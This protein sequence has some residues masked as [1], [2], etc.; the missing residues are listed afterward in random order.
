MSSA[1]PIEVVDTDE[2]LAGPREKHDIQRVL[3][4]ERREQIDL[5]APPEPQA[6]R[7]GQHDQGQRQCGVDADAGDEASLPHCSSLLPLPQQTHVQNVARTLIDV[8]PSPAPNPSPPSS[9][10]PPATP[11][12]GR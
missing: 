12:G 3:T 1:F 6:E 8:W 9:S 4:V 10:S 7:R 11:A 5:G 2:E